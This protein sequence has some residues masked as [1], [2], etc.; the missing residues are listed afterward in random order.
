[1]RKWLTLV[2]CILTS[3]QGG[4]IHSSLDKQLVEEELAKIEFASPQSK[5]IT[6]CYLELERL[7]P[8][9]ISA[10]K[11]YSL[12]INIF[13]NNNPLLISKNSDLLRENVTALIDYEIHSLKSPIAT[14]LHKA[15]HKG[16][17]VLRS[18][19]NVIDSPYATHVEIEHINLKLA[20]QAAEEIYKRL[21]IYFHHNLT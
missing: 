17:I 19:H 20:A 15:L 4:G 10:T 11:E 3:C 9:T 14:P 6:E 18:S 7:L 1:M 16:R 5:Y 13:Y 21:F 2:L 8:S 12:N